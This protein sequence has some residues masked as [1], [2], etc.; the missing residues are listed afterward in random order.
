ME[1]HL[2]AT[3]THHVES[4]QEI[5]PPARTWDEII[6]SFSAKEAKALKRKV[7][8]R[9]VVTLGCMYCVSLLDRNNLGNASITGEFV[10]PCELSPTKEL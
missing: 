4:G 10:D 2:D 6:D 1:K 7:D 9:L 5:L 3:E 8:L